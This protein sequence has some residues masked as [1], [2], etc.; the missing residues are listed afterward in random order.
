VVKLTWLAHHFP[1]LNNHDDNVQQLERF[2]R[3]WIL[4]FIG[5]ILFVDKGSSKVSLRYLQFLRDF[6]QCSTYAWGPAV[7]AYLYR[8][9]QCHRLQ[10]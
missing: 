6:G 4:R 9:V 2:T 10:N 7:L 3:T 8:D 1:Q 5:G